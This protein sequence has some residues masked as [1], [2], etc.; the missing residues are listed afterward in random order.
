MEAMA[1]E[2]VRARA[3]KWREEAEPSAGRRVVLR[4]LDPDEA[5]AASE[6][7][8]AVVEEA[9]VVAGFVVEDGAKCQ[10]LCAAADDA[11][12]DCGSWLRDALATLGGRGGGQ[13]GFARGGCQGVT[14]AEVMARLR[15]TLGSDPQD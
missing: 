9:G 7:I 11:G 6:A 10:V 1:R 13:P 4:V 8:H 15:E 5:L 3:Q 12:V 2:L 14:A